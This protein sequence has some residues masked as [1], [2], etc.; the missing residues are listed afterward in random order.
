VRSTGHNIR[1]R[2]V[3][4]TAGPQVQGRSASYGKSFARGFSAGSSP[5]RGH[6]V[7]N[8]VRHSTPYYHAEV[9]VGWPKISIPVR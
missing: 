7:G 3:D 5:K 1:R 2:G 8:K 9:A 6:P 4:G